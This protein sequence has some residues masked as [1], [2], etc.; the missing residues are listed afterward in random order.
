MVERAIVH[1]F[2]A[3]SLVLL[4]F[5]G[6]R[7]LQRRA[8]GDWLPGNWQPTLALAAVTVFA[9]ASLRE[10]YDVSAG[11]PLAKAFTDYA[12]WLLGAGFSVWGLY[13]FKV[14]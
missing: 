13:R 3:S 14:D 11:Q 2:S 1:F 10:A 8:A 6:L 7:T 12:S 5:F 9:L 4:A